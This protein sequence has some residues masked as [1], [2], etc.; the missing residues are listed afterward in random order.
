MSTNCLERPWDSPQIQ[1]R[2][3]L[4]IFQYRMSGVEYLSTTISPPLL[5]N[6]GILQI[7]AA[8]PRPAVT[9]LFP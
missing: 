8:G 4:T 2:K 9:G 5:R 7:F 1:P 6:T 3:N